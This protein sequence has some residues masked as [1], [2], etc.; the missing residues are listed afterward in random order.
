MRRHHCCSRKQTHAECRTSLRSILWTQTI[1]LL[2]RANRNVLKINLCPNSR[3]TRA[4]LHRHNGTRCI[5][6]WLE[7]AWSNCCRAKAFTLHFSL[8]NTKIDDFGRYFRQLLSLHMYKQVIFPQKET[9]GDCIKMVNLFHN[10][11]QHS[12]E[13][14]DRRSARPREP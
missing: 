10:T 8:H 11:C 1:V 12:T 9:A 4:I 5:W 2:K 3:T 7:P 14:N 13:T 6:S